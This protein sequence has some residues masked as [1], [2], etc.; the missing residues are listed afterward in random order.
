MSFYSNI[1]SGEYF[2]ILVSCSLFFQAAINSLFY[3]FAWLWCFK[4]QDVGWPNRKTWLGFVLHQKSFFFMTK[5]VVDQAKKNECLFALLL[6]DWKRLP[7]GQSW[8]CK[9]ACSPSMLIRIFLSA[10]S[11]LHIVVNTWTGLLNSRWCHQTE[12]KGHV[13]S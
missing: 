10:L 7:S 4:C 2:T 6:S 12:R 3:D 9:V 13:T 11:L 1:M 5:K 8:W